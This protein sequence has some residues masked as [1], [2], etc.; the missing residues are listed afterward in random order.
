MHWLFGLEPKDK[1]N[2]EE[3]AYRVMLVAWK[4][5]LTVHTPLTANKTSGRNGAKMNSVTKRRCFR[6]HGCTCNDLW[7]WPHCHEKCDCHTV[8]LRTWSELSQSADCQLVRSR[9]SSELHSCQAEDEDEVVQVQDEYF[10]LVEFHSSSLFF[11]IFCFLASSVS[12]SLTFNFAGD[13]AR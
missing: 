11:G 10:H 1:K 13:L 9:V 12:S 8:A 6:R 5:T 3:C 2:K 7:R 4:G